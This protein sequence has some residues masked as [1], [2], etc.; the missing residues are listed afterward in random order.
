LIRRAKANS[1]TGILYASTSQSGDQGF[2]LLEKAVDTLLHLPELGPAAEVLWQMRFEQ[3]P[4][5][6]TTSVSSTH[7]HDHILQFAPSQLDLALDDGV[8]E[9]VKTVW[10]KIVGDHAGDFLVFEDREANVDD[11]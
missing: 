5:G 3:R 1:L 8:L 10:E 9:E 2:Q 11:D 4:G 7:T 6:S